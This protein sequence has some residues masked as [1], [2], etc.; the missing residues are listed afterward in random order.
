MLSLVVKVIVAA[1]RHLKLPKKMCAVTI[2]PS[3]KAYKYEEYSAESET[4]PDMTTTYRAHSVVVTI[5][6]HLIWTR[7]EPSCL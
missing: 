1:P 6:E 7:C 4:V 5:K 2:S 3:T